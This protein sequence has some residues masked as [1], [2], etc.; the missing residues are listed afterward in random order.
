[1]SYRSRL[2][3]KENE[4]AERLEAWIWDFFK[5]LALI[6]TL[7]LKNIQ[8]IPESIGYYFKRKEKQKVVEFFL[9][10]KNILVIYLLPLPLKFTLEGSSGLSGFQMGCVLNPYIDI[11]YT[12]MV[13]SNSHTK[14][15]NMS[16]SDKV[17]M[18]LL[19]VFLSAA[20]IC[21]LYFIN[22]FQYFV[23]LLLLTL[24]RQW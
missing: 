24:I 8:T 9:L 16:F 13:I 12:L 21:S 23:M 22:S 18:E 2:F 10:L 1:M 17:E 7:A 4:L 19:H 5:I 15:P 6:F 11:Y 3:S 20:I 14:Q